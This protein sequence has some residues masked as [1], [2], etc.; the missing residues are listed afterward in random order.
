MSISG[1][2]A[3]NSKKLKAWCE[4]LWAS[5]KILEFWP[6]FGTIWTLFHAL[7]VHNGFTRPPGGFA[8][9]IS[10]PLAALM[11][12][13]AYPPIPYPQILNDR[14]LILW[15]FVEIHN[16]KYIYLKSWDFSEHSH[17][18]FI[19]IYWFLTYCGI[20]FE[21]AKRETQSRPDFN[22]LLKAC[23]DY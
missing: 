22:R 2:R 8:A 16:E 3:P 21:Q 14:S 4:R 20:S 9:K 18:I 19:H 11:P 12:K 1:S 6:Y 5:E 23:I 17:I 13:I 10:Y 15:E 7:Y